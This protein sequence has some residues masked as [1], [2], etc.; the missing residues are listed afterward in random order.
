MLSDLRFAFRQL[1]KSPGFAAVAILTLALGIGA[2][3]AVF[4]VVNAVLLRPLPFAEPQQL[5]MLWTD[6][7]SLNLG[8]HEVPPTPFDL[9]AWR[10]Q[11][12][13]FEQIAAISP[14]PA[15]LSGDGAPERVGGVRVTPNFFPLL[16]V[17]PRL[18]RAFTVAEEQPGHDGVAIISDALWQ[19]R[20]GG[21]AHILG[22]S[23]MV[24]RA[25]RTVVGVMPPRFDF[26]RGTEMPTGYGLLAETHVWVPFAEDAAWW[27]ERGNRNYLALARI[28]S[29]L[30]LAQAQAEMTAIAAQQAKE[31]PDSHGGWIV[32]LRTLV[33]QTT[34]RVRPVL[35]TLTGAV[36]CVLLIACVNVANLLL[37]RA[38][39]RRGE[40]AVRAALGASRGRVVRQLVTE[41]LLLSACGGT[42]G[43]LLGA[44]GIELLVWLSPPGFPSLAGTTLDGRVLLVTAAVSLL[45]G[46]VFG[47]APAWQVSKF[48]LTDALHT[49]G[50]RAVGGRNRLL[51]VLVA[52]EVALAVALLI[53]AG[54]MAKSLR[55]LEA[56]DPGFD[57]HQVAAFDVSLADATYKGTGRRLQF[58]QG[59]RTRL[60][61]LPGVQSASAISAAPLSG[62]ENL[63]ALNI[64]G[65]PA[66]KPG[67]GIA[68]ESRDTLPGYFATMGVTLLRGRDFD[69][70]DTA[71]KP[72]V[73][74]INET[75]ARTLFVGVD[76]IGQRVR[77]GADDSRNPWRTIIGV[78]HDVRGYALETK[79]RPQVYKP[80]ERGAPE[81]MTFVVRAGF[82]AAGA[83]EQSIRTDMKSLDPLL[84]AANYRTMERLVANAVARPRFSAFLFGF[85]AATALLLALIGLYGVVAYAVS[86]RTREIGIR[87]ALGAQARDIRALVLRQGLAPALAGLAV[88]IFGAFVL[89]RFLT[90][91]LYEIS[92]TDP[93][94]FVA[95][96][97]LIV[98]VALAA[99]LLPARRAT[100]VDPM[101]ALRAE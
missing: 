94:T 7:P 77:L 63:Q 91:Q 79:P 38:V 46:L 51:A 13:S 20:F 95:V 72:R 24:N 69:A 28:K 92:A 68:T 100:K 15:D 39:G 48:N 83:L 99:C 67:A 58:Y 56:V 18:G 2:N 54:L 88:G 87:L 42:L 98:V 81:E 22:K 30:T 33:E 40:I 84:P 86:Q 11:A 17:S 32:H 4:S 14:N 73:C 101:I 97:A 76:P 55:R 27:Q 47:L 9:P 12:H 60:A 64:E 71:D 3:T 75:A 1:A 52:S 43:T 89:T 10:T 8:F 96:A 26:P 74:I 70:Q 25:L 31:F 34:G 36:A 53:G 61:A 35:L 6:N 85:F 49:A 62:R 93:A 80:A 5:A 78:A 59:A 57:G 44:W 19:R 23:I 65:R 37:C 29:G 90:A 45:T 50:N 66:P 82:A 41:S 16:G 21:D